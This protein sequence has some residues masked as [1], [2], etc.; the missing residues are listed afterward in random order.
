MQVKVFLN[1]VEALFEAMQVKVSPE[2]MNIVVP[3]LQELKEEKS[4]KIE[5][6]SKW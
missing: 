5:R 6:K 3:S 4:K 1:D 2:Q